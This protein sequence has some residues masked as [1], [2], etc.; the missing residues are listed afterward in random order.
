MARTPKQFC[1]EMKIIHP[2]IEEIG[3][4]TK[5]FAWLLRV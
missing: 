5:A 2:D 1:D 3:L 4:Y